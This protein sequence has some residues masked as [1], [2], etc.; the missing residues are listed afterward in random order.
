VG[1]L[2]GHGTPLP[3]LVTGYTASSDFPT[4]GMAF[5]S[6]SNGGSDAFIANILAV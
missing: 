1:G 2:L 3:L 4:T 5:D 6:G